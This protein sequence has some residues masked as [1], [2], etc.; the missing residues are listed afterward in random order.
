MDFWL[1]PV[2]DNLVPAGGY[3]LQQ[4]SVASLHQHGPLPGHRPRHKYT[5][6]EET[7]GQVCVHNHVVSLTSSVP[8]HLHS[9]DYYYEIPVYPHSLL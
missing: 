1:K 8:A 5:D 2:Q 9:S 6:P 7:L 4:C 3:L